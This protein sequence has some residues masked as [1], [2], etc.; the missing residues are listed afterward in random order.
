MSGF[1]YLLV[2]SYLWVVCQF[3]IQSFLPGSYDHNHQATQAHGQ[4]DQ[5]TPDF[6]PGIFAAIL[7]CIVIVFIK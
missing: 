5:T 2:F 7:S 1:N 4:I 3:I 6:D